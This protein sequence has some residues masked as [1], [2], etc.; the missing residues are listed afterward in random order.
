MSTTRA[1]REKR[2]ERKE[3]ARHAGNARW[4]CFFPSPHSLDPDADSVTKIPGNGFGPDMLER[5]LSEAI[6][7]DLLFGDGLQL[8][9]VAV[10]IGQNY[11]HKACSISLLDMMKKHFACEAEVSTVAHAVEVRV[12][13]PSLEVLSKSTLLEKLLEAFVHLLVHPLKLP[14]ECWRPVIVVGSEKSTGAQDTC[15]LGQ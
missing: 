14:I 3:K 11:L 6:K 9:L 7:T 13:R 15:D 10:R 4:A 8:E 2:K 12:L 1:Q 5:G